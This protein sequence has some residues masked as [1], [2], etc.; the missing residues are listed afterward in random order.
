MIGPKNTHLISDTAK[1]LE[2]RVGRSIRFVS[3]AALI[4]LGVGASVS[5]GSDASKKG[6]SEEVIFQQATKSQPNIVLILAD[7]LGW[8]DLG[9]YGSEIE[10]P[11][12][13]RLANEGI[14]FTQFHN[15]SKCSTSRASLLTGL[16]AQQV[17][18]SQL[19]TKQIQN[20]VPLGEVLRGAGYSTLAVGKHHGKDNLFERGFDRYWGLRDGATNHFNPGEQRPG[21]AAPAFKRQPRVWCFDAECSAPYTPPNKDY[22]SSDAFTTWAINFLDDLQKAE[23]T[24]SKPFFLYL[25]FQAPHDPLQA[26]PQDIA[27][28]RGNYLGGDLSPVS[29]PMLG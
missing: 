21:E 8:S 24:S 2:L 9:S 6:L 14:R 28:Y 17:N 20:G 16:Y 25:S 29:V 15:T 5:F 1:W 23:D 19:L 11:N 12:L 10:T 7:D 3:Y 27:K 18:M 22:Y 26:W 13:D 4:L